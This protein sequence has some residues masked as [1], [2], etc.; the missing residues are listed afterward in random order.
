MARR[1]PNWIDKYVAT[2]AHLEAPSKF[3]LWTALSTLASAVG[4]R[5]YLDE[6]TFRYYPNMFI[7][8]VAPPGVSTKSI[9]MGIG[10]KYLTE[11]D[12]VNM[13][14]DSTSFQQ[15][16]HLISETKEEVALGNFNYEAAC[17]MTLHVSELG[18]FLQDGDTGM[19][20]ALIELYDCRSFQRSTINHGT[21][22]IENPAL[23]LIGGT[24]PSW[25]LQNFH[26]YFKDGGLGSRCIFVYAEEKQ[27]FVAFPG[28]CGVETFD[29]DLLFDLRQIS[30]LQGQ[31]Y[32]TEDA[33][34]YATKWYNSH[35]RSVKLHPLNDI[36]PG[37]L[38]RKFAH[39]QKIALLRSI[40]YSDKLIITKQDFLWALE[41][42]EAMELDMQ[43]IIG[44][45]PINP[46]MILQGSILNKLR[47]AKRPL[48]QQE[49]YKHFLTS[50]NRKE[51]ESVLS[52]LV[53]AEKITLLQ[54]EGGTLVSIYEEE[55]QDAV[56]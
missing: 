7:I 12:G 25:M 42:I 30:T 18:N 28:D 2:T 35:C 29:D 19:V 32:F 24:T 55:V 36:L 38:S 39:I 17:Q 1:V 31:A 48:K 51:F 41:Q 4:R 10:K 43:K 8:F 27:N 22:E 23:N 14:P 3:Q 49:L 37:Y 16:M 11:I 13:G 53:Y 21:K 6:R 20:N 15:L 54:G 34:V 50:V 26:G 44:M 46:Y 5:V 40:S 52:A 9:T 33:K 45:P 47:D 56:Q